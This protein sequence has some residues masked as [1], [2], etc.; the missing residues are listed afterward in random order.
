MNLV[1]TRAT[2]AYAAWQAS[3]IQAEGHKEMYD[4]LRESYYHLFGALKYYHDCFK[5]PGLEREEY[6]QMVKIG[7]NSGDTTFSRLYESEL[8]KVVH[9]LPSRT[10]SRENAQG[11]GESSAP[12]LVKTAFNF[13]RPPFLAA[14][15]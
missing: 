13:A 14:T 8:V 9:H 11:N 4:R 10:D 1:Q 15:T 3:L 12:R 2:Q 5:D 7:G 6:K